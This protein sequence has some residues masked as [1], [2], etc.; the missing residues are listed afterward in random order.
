VYDTSETIHNAELL[1]TKGFDVKHMPWVESALSRIVNAKNKAIEFA[2]LRGCTHIL[3]VD[4][5]T[6]IP[7]WS[8]DRLIS[9]KNG[10]VGWVASIGKKNVTVPSVFR[11]PLQYSTPSFDCRDVYD[12]QEIYG[13]RGELLKVFG[14]N[15]GLISMEVLK[16]IRFKDDST[17]KAN[18]ESTLGEDLRFWQDCKDAGIEWYCDTGLFVEHLSVEWEGIIWNKKEDILWR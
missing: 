16:T 13:R 5:D 17:Q 7:K 11:S 18:G 8:L 12:W 9:H 15:F 14:C 2:E 10:C 4:S 3:F 6:I 1:R